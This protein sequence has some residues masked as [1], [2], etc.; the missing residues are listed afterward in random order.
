MARLRLRVSR[1]ALLAALVAAAGGGL[2]G[3]PRAAG[4]A[5]TPV[6]LFQSD[7]LPPIGS[8]EA[9]EH[10][11]A[12]TATRA[13]DRARVDL[14]YHGGAVMREVRLHALYW[15]PAGTAFPARYRETVD[16]FLG[17]AAAASGSGETVFS[18][19][20]QYG[21]VA[22]RYT[23]AGS[24]VV[25][26]P[27]PTRDASCDLNGK[28]A[29]VTGAQIADRV[30]AEVD[31]RGWS[32][33]LGDLTLV[34]LPSDVRVCRYA[35]V[36]SD[37]TFCAYHA[38]W[39]ADTRLYVFAVEP[40]ES[41]FG[42]CHPGAYPT[43]V[44][45]ADIAINTSAHEINE[46]V[47]NPSGGGWWD[48][49][50][51]EE[52]ADICSWQFG[53]PLGGSGDTRWNQVLNG[54]RYWLQ[55]SWSNDGSRCVW[56]YTGPIEPRVAGFAPAAAAVGDTVTITGAALGGVS[57]VTFNGVAAASVTQVSAAEVRAVVP[58]TASSGP[59]SVGTPEGT[60]TTDARFGLVPRI[61]AVAPARGRVGDR[62]VVTGSGLRETSSVRFGAVAAAFSV[63]PDGS[64]AATV[65]AGAHSGAV[66][67]EAP[68]GSGTRADAFGVLPT[69][70][71]A[72]TVP[73]RAGKTLTL[74]GV[75]LA[76]TTAVTVG[77]RAWPFRALSDSVVRVTVPPDAR[78]GPVV[79]ANPAGGTNAGTAV[80]VPRVTGVTPTRAAVGTVVDVLGTGLADVTS[81]TLRGVPVAFAAHGPNRVS[82][83]VPEGAAS[84]RVV[85]A[86]AGGTSGR[87]LA[88]AKPAGSGSARA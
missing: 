73:L 85:V 60:A 18:S 79:V 80:L 52:N 61:G 63:E 71:A 37:Q 38:A 11:R 62:V 35:G 83:T 34:Y 6:A 24:E 8:E 75:S 50:T 36:C 72:G 65:P 76:D 12:A 31:A 3:L 7:G 32:P 22:Y 59:I 48:D 28:S 23:F 54:N 81:V 21:D 10:A 20:S 56:T 45:A 5:D 74:R 40:E 17:D 25:T 46:A 44:K 30:M 2:V 55:G 1:A 15:Q 33:G 66:T 64:L 9:E 47:T 14:E 88:I 41:T 26:D 51:G 87:G 13:S 77:G 84:G 49:S 78:S 29:C 19:N 42:G 43:G 70:S 16:R 68:G 57:A 86:A 82:F 69:V 39:L 53:T 27:F 58:E 4:A 67:V